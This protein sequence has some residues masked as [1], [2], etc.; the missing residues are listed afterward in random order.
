MRRGEIVDD[1]R[2]FIGPMTPFLEIGANAG[3]SSYMLANQYGAEGFALD[4]S[5]DSL[6]YGIALRERWQLE[7]SPMLVAGDALHLPFKDNSL[8][9]VVAFQMLSQFMDIESVFLEVKRVLQPGGIFFFAEEPMRRLL[10]ARLYR[11]PYYDTMKP[12][13]RKLSD[14]GLLGF[15]VKDVI[16]AHQEESFG[17]RQNHRMD[18][19]DWHRL[20]KKHFD[21]QRYKLFVPEH[22]W[23]ETL[24]KK[25]AIQLDPNKSEWRAA[26]LMGGTLGAICRKAG[27]APVQTGPVQYDKLLRCPDCGGDMAR[28]ESH[29]ICCSS[30]SYE[31]P[32]KDGVYNLL[33]SHDKRELYPGER[34]DIIDFSLPSHEKHLG[35][36]WYDIE[37]VYGNKFRWIGARAS[38]WLEN[39]KGGEQRLRLRGFAPE[40]IFQASPRPVVEVFVNGLPLKA[41]PLDRNG[42]FALETNLPAAPRYELEIRVSPVWR[43]PND[44]RE[45]SVNF[46]MLRLIPFEA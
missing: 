35:H 32:W 43:A 19:G 1:L 40:P 45:L 2:E 21:D 23:A 13:E 14:W 17:I 26:R 6:R 7:K 29:A 41:W 3:H 44:T 20:I 36:G 27:E 28:N 38:A 39:V 5:E 37:G 31:A 18:L 33:P 24:V 34:N 11:C 22:G 25:I 30:C 9:M 15:L 16:G 4:I 42:L 12:W 8:R 10:T 46:G